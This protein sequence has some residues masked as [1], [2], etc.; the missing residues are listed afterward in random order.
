[1]PSA[2]FCSQC[3]KRIKLS[4]TGVLLFRSFC[5]QCSPRFWRFRLTLIAIPVLCGAVGFAIGHYAFA[6]EPFYLIGTPI[7]ASASR[8]ASSADPTGDHSPRGSDAPKKREQPGTSLSTTEAIC[9]ARTRSGRPCQRR[10]KGGG[11]CWQHRT[12]SE[13]G[14]IS[15]N[16]K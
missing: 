3:G 1:M 8:V 10:V 6:R 9:G 2:R 12:Q 15:P 5:P 7:D 11:L 14:Q 16:K 4:H 13:S